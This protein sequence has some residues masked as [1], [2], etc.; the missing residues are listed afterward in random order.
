ME[1]KAINANVEEYDNGILRVQKPVENRTPDDN[2]YVL[3]DKTIHNGTIEMDV[4]GSLLPTADINDRGFIGLA[5][6]INK[7]GSEFECFY[8]RP[9]NGNTKDPVRKAHGCQYFSYPGYTF[10][11]YRKHGIL[12]MEAPIEGQI[13]KWFHLKAEIEKDHA[14]FYVDGI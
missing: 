7:D 12:G 3:L 6:R 11:Y 9:T 2:T 4:K 1:W 14:T 8:I 5:F 10:A 13:D